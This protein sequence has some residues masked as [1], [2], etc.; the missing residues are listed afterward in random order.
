MSKDSDNALPPTLFMAF[1][2]VKIRNALHLVMKGISKTKNLEGPYFIKSIFLRRKQSPPQ[3]ITRPSQ[4]TE[5]GHKRPADCLQEFT[6][7]TNFCKG[8][9]GATPPLF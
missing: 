4:R 5:E 8:R 1:C 3:S 9:I 7:I 2:S 6:V